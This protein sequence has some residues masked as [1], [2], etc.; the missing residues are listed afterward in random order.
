M[1]GTVRSIRIAARSGFCYG[2]REAIDAAMLAGREGPTATLGAIVHNEGANERLRAAGV[3]RIEAI[4]EAPDGSTV[5]I[6]AHGTTPAVR[7][8]A[9][10]RNLH[11]I[12]G[13]CS[14]VTAEHR[15]MERLVDS[16]A[17]IILLGTPGHPETVGLLGY[18]PNAIVVDE[19]S[20]WAEKI[21]PRK[22]MALISQST[23]P[24]WKFER[25]AAFMAARAHEL[26][27]INTVCP[28]TIRRQQDTVEM[29]RAVDAVIVVGG[30]SSA[31]TKELV[32]LV[33]EIEGKPTLFVGS[34][35]EIADPAFFEGHATIGITGGTSTPIED[36]AAVAR[37]VIELAGTTTAQAEVETLVVE[38]MAGGTARAHR[39]TSL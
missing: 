13:T 8:T 29:A 12:D 5:V 19:E 2:V 24:P 21:T 37:R 27:V 34:A 28:V 31:N 23:Q 18:A 30:K 36:I 38:A 26:T 3:G 15:E 16:G 9:A 39:T 33:A 17:T 32:R 4:D 14:W 1:T 35:A 7:A 10:T 11:V 6:R 20:E 25:L 22:R